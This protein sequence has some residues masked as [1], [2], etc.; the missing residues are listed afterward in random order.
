MYDI[1]KD[2]KGHIDILFANAGI[3]EFAPLGEISEKHFDKI[4]DIDVKGLVIY[5][6]KSTSNFSGW[7][8]NHFDW[9][10]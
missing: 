2:Q 6:S 7:R 9:L 1:V 4:F 5:C 10:L 3:I 8:F